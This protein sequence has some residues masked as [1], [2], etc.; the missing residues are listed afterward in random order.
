MPSKLLDVLRLPGLKLLDRM[1]CAVAAQDDSGRIV[2]VNPAFC[3]E[4]GVTAESAVGRVAAAQVLAAERSLYVDVMR[5]WR[6]GVSRPVRV[7]ARLRTG[8]LRPL[9]ILPQPL[10][11]AAGEPAG[12]L[13]LIFDPERVAGA[14]ADR[15]QSAG[16]LLRSLLHTI[17]DEIDQALERSHDL[18]G[19]VDDLRRRVPALRSL[20]QREWAVASRIAG[21]DRTS[22]VAKDLGIST[23][24][25]RNH[26]KAIFRK[27]RVTSQ[28]GLVEAFKKW[29]EGALPGAR[30]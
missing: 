28:V 10:T 12:A 2:Y 21:G 14:A 9:L 11:D 8:E 1:A 20:T 25:V 6:E 18:H 4:L 19:D 3:R 23:N 24:T 17:T 7:N 30:A 5:E 15:I 29:R 27:L 13:L 22:L 26:L 16:V